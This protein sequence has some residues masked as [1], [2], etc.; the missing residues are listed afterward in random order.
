MPEPHPLLSTGLERFIQRLVDKWLEV[1]CTCVAWTCYIQ[2]S[3]RVRFKENPD[4]FTPFTR[5]VNMQAGPSRFL[6]HSRVNSEPPVSSAPGVMIKVASLSRT[7]H[8]V[9]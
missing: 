3:D 5:W 2:Y 1:F 4:P 9:R 6:A 7:F 8:L